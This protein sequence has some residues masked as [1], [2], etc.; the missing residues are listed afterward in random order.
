MLLLIKLF[1][2]PIKCLH[3]H[4]SSLVCQLVVSV[5]VG[6]EVAASL[7]SHRSL[8]GAYP[9][10]VELRERLDDTS[11]HFGADVPLAGVHIVGYVLWREAAYPLE[12]VLA[13]AQT[14]RLRPLDKLP[15]ALDGGGV[16]FFQFH[17]G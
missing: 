5:E 2:Y 17:W 8:A 16:I 3:L 10:E 9:R 4:H 14:L 13:L 12:V 11:E 1:D 15:E 7:H 6:V